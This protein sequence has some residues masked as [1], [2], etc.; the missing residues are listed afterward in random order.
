MNSKTSGWRCR[1]LGKRITSRTEGTALSDVPETGTEDQQ[2]AIDSAFRPGALENEIQ[3]IRALRALL[4]H[5]GSGGRELPELTWNHLEAISTCLLEQIGSRLLP[6]KTAAHA[7]RLR[8]ARDRLWEL[9]A[10]SDSGRERRRQ[11]AADI[12]LIRFL[13]ETFHLPLTD[14]EELHSLTF[15]E[16]GAVN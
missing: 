3:W 4:G 11:A 7:A 2:T 12:R 10:A 8:A 6:P 14:A 15:D 1:G 9:D 13:Q 5:S 16:L